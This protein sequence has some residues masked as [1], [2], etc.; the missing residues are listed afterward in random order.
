MVRKYKDDEFAR[1]ELAI[2]R[3]DFEEKQL[4]QK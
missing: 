2:E 4:N 3:N 1:F